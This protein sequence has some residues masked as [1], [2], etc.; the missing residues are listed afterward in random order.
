[1]L[2]RE[3]IPIFDPAAVGPIDYTPPSF[4]QTETVLEQAPGTPPRGSSC[5]CFFGSTITVLRPP[6]S[7]RGPLVRFS[8]KVSAFRPG[9]Y[10]HNTRSRFRPRISDNPFIA[11]DRWNLAQ[12]DCS[13]YPYSFFAQ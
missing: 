10:S 1:M 13:G 2:L 4:R 8:R 6:V 3:A 5:I 11:I 12:V 9:P 7:Q